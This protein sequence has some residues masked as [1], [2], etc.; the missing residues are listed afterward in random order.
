MSTINE[1]YPE[2]QRTSCSDSA[3]YNIDPD[4]SGCLT[5]HRAFALAQREAALNLIAVWGARALTA[6]PTDAMVINRHV[7]ELSEAFSGVLE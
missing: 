7:R 5:L 4:G 6:L 3:L 2:H 1:D